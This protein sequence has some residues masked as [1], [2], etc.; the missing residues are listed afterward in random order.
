MP[1]APPSLPRGLSLW[2]ADLPTRRTLW[3]LCLTSVLAVVCGVV[4][5]MAL[6]QFP[7][8]LPLGILLGTA[9]FLLAMSRNLG[10]L[11][12]FL[13]TFAEFFGLLQE[14]S[15]V[16]GI[17]LIDILTAL[18]VVPLVIQILR[19]G[20]PFHGAV[21]RRMRRATLILLVLLGGEIL[22]TVLLSEQ[23]LW[24]SLKAAKPYSYYFAFLLVPIYADS[25]AKIRRLGAGMTA[26]ASILAFMYLLISM[27]GEIPSLPGLIVGEANFVGLGTFTRVRSNGAPL[28]VAML[29]YQFYRYASG[30]ATRL[31]KLALVLLSIGAV[32]HFYRSVWIGV[33]AAVVVQAGIEGKTGARTLGK[34][35]LGLLLLSVAMGVINRDYGEM[36]LS[37]ALSTVTEVEENSG[38]YG[39]RQEQIEAWAPILQ[40]NWL[41]GIGFLHHD[42][43]VGQQ[44]EALHQLEGT[45]NYD[46][47][48][49]DLMGRLGTLGIILLVAALYLLSRS[50]WIPALAAAGGETAILAKTLAAWLIVGIVSLPGYPLL[51]SGAGIFP[52][53]LLAGM[54]AVLE[55]HD[56]SPRELPGEQEG[57]GNAGR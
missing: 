38:S 29:L 53:A 23:G 40:E 15:E 47:G 11:L 46:I 8:L 42:S 4:Q 34:L 56:E 32:V 7:I 30:R 20:F 54:L 35:L 37:R 1:D 6:N 31:G 50:A 5:M 28:V 21:G 14:S 26:I 55:E 18:L 27:L 22:L 52:L 57:S 10:A 49:V 2:W 9:Y 48:W 12:I 3:V 16:N 19:S 41:V 36:I 24:L 51:S 39:V 44:M 33:L 45:G 25:P 17:K 43:T 13:L